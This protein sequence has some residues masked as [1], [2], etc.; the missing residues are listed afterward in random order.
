VSGDRLLAIDQLRAAIAE[1]SDRWQREAA[2]ASF[3]EEHAVP[4]VEGN[5]ATF[6]VLAEADSVYL[7]HRVNPW[8]DDLELARIPGTDLW[9]LTIELD[10]GR[11]WSTS[12]RSFAMG[13]G[14]DSMTH[15]TRDWPGVR[16]GTARCARDRVMPRPIGPPFKLKLIPGS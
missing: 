13:N 8:P 9:F 5:V 6:A 14:G 15:T 3:F 10:W 2:T 11:G 1:L 12:S 16:W 4:L 7:R